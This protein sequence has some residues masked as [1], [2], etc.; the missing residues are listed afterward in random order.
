MPIIVPGRS[1]NRFL[2]LSRHELLTTLTIA[3]MTGITEGAADE[4]SHYLALDTRLPRSA[5]GWLPTAMGFRVSLG[6]T[7]RLN[8]SLSYT[9]LREFS[10]VIPAKAGIRGF[11]SVR[12]M[13]RIHLGFIRWG[14]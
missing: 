13:R 11:L 4:E 6:M 14:K 9:W 7:N 8:D 12:G 10:S 3:G 1:C 5:E 2:V